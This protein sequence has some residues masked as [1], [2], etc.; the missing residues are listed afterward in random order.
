MTTLDAILAELRRQAA[1]PM[2]L[3]LLDDEPTGAVVDGC[4]DL[5]ALAA[6]IDKARADEQADTARKIDAIFA[7]N[8]P[9]ENR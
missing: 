6:A 7:D 4:V 3:Y 9:G 1:E 8:N 5:V 2:G